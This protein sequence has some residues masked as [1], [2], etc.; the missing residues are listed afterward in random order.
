MDKNSSLTVFSEEDL[1]D[2]LNEDGKTAI[3]A[4]AGDPVS[5]GA[6]L[7]MMKSLPA[8]ISTSVTFIKLEKFLRGMYP[9]DL[10]L[11]ERTRIS[12]TLFGE[13]IRERRENAIRLFT[14]VD[15]IDSIIK[16]EYLI[17]AGEALLA[18]MITR[19][20]Y[21]RIGMA[22]QGTLLEDLF[23]LKKHAT[24][25]NTLSGCT[26]VHALVRVGAMISAGVNGEKEAENQDYYITEFGRL[27]DRYALSYNDDDRE[28]EYKKMKIQNKKV[29]DGSLEWNYLD[30]SHELKISNKN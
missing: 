23:Y 25:P 9:K 8:Q 26:A 16:I 21:Y 24:T 1:K 13:D 30:D 28:K 10:S 2:V 18:N 17:Q 3:N 12:A 29:R 14:L 20:D 22:I 11:E 27:I 7:N 5:I 15:K 19:E 4:I 6:V